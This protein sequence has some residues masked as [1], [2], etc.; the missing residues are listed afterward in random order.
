MRNTRYYKLIKLMRPYQWIKNTLCFAGIAFGLHFSEPILLKN[1]IFA[2]IAFCLIASSVYIIN[3]II[4][5]N[6]D[7]KHPKK[8]FRPI[9]AGDVTVL[10]AKILSIGL[11]LL[12]CLIAVW[13]SYKLLLLLVLYFGMNIYYSYYG[14]HVVILDV[15]IISFG[16]LL[17]LLA[18]TSAIKIPITG[19]ITLCV[20]MLTLFLGFAKRRAE[21]LFCEVNNVQAS[22]KRRVLEHYEPRMLDI[23]LAITACGSVLGYS[24]FSVIAS[25]HKNIIYTVIF[26][27]YGI[28]RYIYMLYKT[29][30]GQDTADDLLD[31]RHLIITVILWIISYIGISLIL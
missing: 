18:G 6:E 10:S 5:V 1:A 2:F 26:V 14:K 25:P 22:L 30:S 16:F 21:L 7:R 9:A 20:I 3:D 23:F 28:F 8:K 24:L 31:D 27:I 15:F 19:W 12:A 4:D 17:R 11:A 29:E 13:V